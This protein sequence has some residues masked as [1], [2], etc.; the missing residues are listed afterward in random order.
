MASTIL[1]GAIFILNSSSF[2][3][4]WRKFLV[5]SVPLKKADA[6]IVLGGEPSARPMLAAK[7]FKKG[8]ACRVF[9][10]GIGD[11]VRN[12]QVL[13]TSGVPRDVIVLESKANSTYSNARLLKPMLEQY[14]VHSALIVTSPFHTRRALATFRKVIPNIDFGVVEASIPWWTTPQG[15]LDINRFACVEFLKTAEYWLIYGV[16]PFLKSRA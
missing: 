5:V 9:V 13:L 6:L 2:T 3:D 4:I 1:V 14:N 7:L 12:R 10:T 16:S 15:S 8:V 11:S